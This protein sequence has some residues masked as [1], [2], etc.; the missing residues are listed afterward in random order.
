MALNLKILI[1][2][3]L[4]GNYTGNRLRLEKMNAKLA[5]CNRWV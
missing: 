2:A 3:S 4:N 1:N 5:K